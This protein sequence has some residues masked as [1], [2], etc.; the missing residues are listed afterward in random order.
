VCSYPTENFL[1]SDNE[2]F[3]AASDLWAHIEMLINEEKAKRIVPGAPALFR[4]L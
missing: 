2:L 1:G 4:A 3:L